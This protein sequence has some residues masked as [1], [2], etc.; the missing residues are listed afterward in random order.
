MTETEIYAYLAGIL[1]GE[2]SLMIRKS[3]Y[4]LRNPKFADCKNPSYNPRIGVKNTNEDVIK[5][6]KQVFHGHYHKDKKLYPSKWGVHQ[7]KII[8]SYGAEHRLAVVICKTLMPYLI[9]K[10]KQAE[11]L[12]ELNALK[13]LKRSNSYTLEMIEK[14]EKLYREVKHLND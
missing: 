14:F 8:Y 6:F 4:R 2:G 13:H 11:K 3:T 5:L 9:I 7:N 12:L 10:K 1:D